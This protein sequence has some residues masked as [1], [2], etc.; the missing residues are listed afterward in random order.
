MLCLDSGHIGMH[1]DLHSLFGFRTHSPQTWL[2]IHR[3]L[4]TLSWKQEEKP[5]EKKE[6]PAPEAGKLR[7]LLPPEEIEQW[8][9]IRGH[10]KVY[11]HYT[12]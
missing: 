11:R 5:P 2:P 9:M 7:R 4:G 10:D 12:L 6:E 8:D 3:A 1:Q